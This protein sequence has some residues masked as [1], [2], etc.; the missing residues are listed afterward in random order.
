MS[1]LVNVTKSSIQTVKTQNM[2]MLF[3]LLHENKNLS[4]VELKRMTGLSPTTVSSLIDELIEKELVIETGILDTGSIGRKAVSLTINPKGRHFVG[5]EI[6]GERI[7]IDI[8]DLTFF[9]VYH[10]EKELESY[11]DTLEFIVSSL[12]SMTGMK[13]Y[14]VI[15]GFSGVLTKKGANNFISTVT[16]IS[17][18]DL[19]R[20]VAEEFPDA[21]VE[22][23]NSSSLIAFAEKEERNLSDLISIDIG[24]GVGSGII[25]DGKIYKGAGGTAGEF[26][27]ISVNM[28]GPLC[29][30]GNRGCT[31]LY[32]NTGVIRKKATEILKVEKVSL[33]A[34]YNE[35]EKGNIEIIKMISEIAEILSVALVGL[36]NMMAP[37][38]VVIGGKIKELGEFFLEPLKKAVEE[39]CF[40]GETKIEYSEVPG[41]SATLGAAKYSYTQM[42]NTI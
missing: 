34:I 4:R 24:K 21:S 40:I 39:K 2:N 31:E 30:C 20:D 36:I 42:F 38:S 35:A 27:H 7:I 23:L 8:Y 26:G 29:K 18:G 22:L 16:D 41:N 3:N 9:R 12:K 37:E 33:K 5:I 25:I 17:Y 14:S 19:A 28:E 1:K 11:E 10:S 32:T 6:D 13:I 15:I